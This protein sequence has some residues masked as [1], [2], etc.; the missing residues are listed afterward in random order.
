[1]L[2]TVLMPLIKLWTEVYRNFRFHEAEY[3]WINANIQ[4]Y[5]QGI[6]TLVQSM[7]P[8]TVKPEYDYEKRLGKWEW[9]VYGLVRNVY[10]NSTFH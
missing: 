7:I 2:H 8:S 5:D 4:I 10:N 1:M 6:N 9:P 3:N